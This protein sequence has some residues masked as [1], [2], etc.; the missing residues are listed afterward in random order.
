MGMSSCLICDTHGN[1]IA[2]PKCGIDGNVI[3][4]EDFRD[5]EDEPREEE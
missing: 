3:Y 5:E 2:C 1:F 4:D